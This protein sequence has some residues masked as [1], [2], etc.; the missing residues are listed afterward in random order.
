MKPTTTV[1]KF[2]PPPPQ[3]RNLLPRWLWVVALI[4]NGVGGVLLFL[5]G[6]RQPRDWIW[7]GSVVVIGLAALL[8]PR[9]RRRQRG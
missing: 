4:A 9:R 1:A 7:R 6:E 3:E 2:P 8:L 5:S